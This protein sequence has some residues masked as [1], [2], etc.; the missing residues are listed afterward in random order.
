MG[1]ASQPLT[2]LLPTNWS[3]TNNLANF[4]F[5]DNSCCTGFQK[6]KLKLAIETVE[7]TGN[8]IKYKCGCRSLQ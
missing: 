8:S 1:D 5:F 3:P 2:T 7:E 4:N 6:K